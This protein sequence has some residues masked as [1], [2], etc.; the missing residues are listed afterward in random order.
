MQQNQTATQSGQAYYDIEL[1][2]ERGRKVMA[3]RGL[4]DKREAEWL[5]E[6]MLL[7]IAES[8]R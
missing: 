2:R 4:R 1:H 6:Q 3:G 5:A 7:Q 8:R